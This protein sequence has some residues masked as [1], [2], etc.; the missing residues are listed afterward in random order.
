MAFKRDFRILRQILKIQSL[1]FH[2]E[3]TGCSNLISLYYM[4][5]Y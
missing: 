1:Q 5:G 2:L 3:A 4:L